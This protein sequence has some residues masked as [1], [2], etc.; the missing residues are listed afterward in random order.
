[1][2]F[3][4]YYWLLSS[5]ACTHGTHRCLIVSS[6]CVYMLACLCLVFMLIL[7]VYLCSHEQKYKG[8]NEG[9]NM[10][11]PSEPG[12]PQSSPRSRSPSPDD[13]LERV[14]ADVKEYER[15]NV[16]TFEE[17]IKAKHN[18]IKQEKDGTLVCVC[19]HQTCGKLRHMKYF[20]ILEPHL[21]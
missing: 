5:T 9:S 19:V 11:A 17:N 4:L 13:I 14:A 1:M 16:D 7:C 12:S 2:P 8:G 21:I 18:F 6:S 15:E 10:S 3:T 20:Q